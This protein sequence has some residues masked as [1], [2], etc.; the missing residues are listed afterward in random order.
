MA[1]S[2]N[3][4]SITVGDVVRGRFKLEAELA[5]GGMSRVYEAVDLRYDR[6]A[7][8]K[9]LSGSLAEDVEFRH[10]SSASR[11]PPSA[12]RTH[13]CCRSGTTAR[14][15][16]SSSWSRRCATRPRRP[17][18][19]HEQLEPTT[20]WVLAQVA[21][22]LDWAHARGVVHR[23]VKPENVLLIAG[24]GTTTPTWPTSAWRAP[25]DDRADA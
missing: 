15:T 4:R 8:V 9:V 3:R 14:T 21:W 18:L 6:P 22:A 25:A 20:R 7:A 13:T 5:E 1:L 11:M 10:A 23:D 2:R 19:E 24:P 17:A 12:S 16:G